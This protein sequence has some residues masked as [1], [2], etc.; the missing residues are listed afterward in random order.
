MTETDP[1]KRLNGYARV[2]TYRQTLDDQIA[3]LC[4]P[5]GRTRFVTVDAMASRIA[6]PG[7]VR[8]CADPSARRR[9]V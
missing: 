1:K 8:L 3:Q 5:R 2:S 7:P 4:H 9:S 6:E